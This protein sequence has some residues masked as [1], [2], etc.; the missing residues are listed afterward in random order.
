MVQNDAVV[1]ENCLRLHKHSIP[2]H[3]LFEQIVCYSFL[4]RAYFC[5]KNIL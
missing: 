1:V 4:C 5:I 2:V 3:M